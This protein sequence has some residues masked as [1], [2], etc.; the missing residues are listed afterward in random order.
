MNS[1]LWTAL[2]KVLPQDM[3]DSFGYVKKRFQDLL[4]DL[5]WH[6]IAENSLGSGAV[7]ATQS[8]PTGMLV[9]I[10]AGRLYTRQGDRILI[11]SAQANVNPM[12]DEDSNAIALPTAGNER[13]VSIFAKPKY[14]TSDSRMTTAAVAFDIRSEE[15]FEIGVEAGTIAAIGAATKPATRDDAVL[16]ADILLQSG[17]TAI[18]DAANPN[19]PAAGEIDLRRAEVMEVRAKR[20]AASDFFRAL[21]NLG[22]SNTN[23]DGTRIYADLVPKAWFSVKWNGSAHVVAGKCNIVSNTTLLSN[24]CTLTL[25]TGLFASADDMVALMTPN[26]IYNDLDDSGVGDDASEITLS[27]TPMSAT[28]VVVSATGPLIGGFIDAGLRP[29]VGYHVVILGRP[30]I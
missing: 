5:G 23:T 11:P 22:A 18:T 13:Y 7:S 27:A 21:S 1:F 17:T 28:T 8:T 4:V 14:V 15:S 10:T 20:I 2:Y 3:L 30:S 12:I 24:T 16:L 19:A 29:G 9:D 6:G 25:P 26:I